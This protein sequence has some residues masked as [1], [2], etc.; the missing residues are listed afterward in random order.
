MMKKQKKSASERIKKFRHEERV[1]RSVANVKENVERTMNT[2]VLVLALFI[3][4]HLELVRVYLCA[5]D[6][7]CVY[8]TCVCCC[9]KRIRPVSKSD[10]MSI[11]AANDD[12]DDD[13]R[14]RVSVFVC[15]SIY[16]PQANACL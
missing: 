4:W 2:F 14:M 5:L 10:R 1:R 13:I 7:L 16:S 15:M 3:L 8:A 12:D 9:S 6:I 11:V